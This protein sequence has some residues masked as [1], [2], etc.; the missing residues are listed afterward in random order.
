MELKRRLKKYVK[1]KYSHREERV[2]GI[3]AKAPNS[4]TGTAT[5]QI[6]A[7]LF[8]GEDLPFHATTMTLSAIRSLI[9]KMQL[10]GEP[11]T[12]KR[13]KYKDQKS[14]YFWIDKL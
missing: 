14:H 10:N 11:V 1:F 13:I 2:F 12:V 3:I 9:K 8:S 6:V 5:P 4:A 7:Q